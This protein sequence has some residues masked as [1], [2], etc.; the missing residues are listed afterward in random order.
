MN[1]LSANCSYL[2][3]TFLSAIRRNAVV[4]STWTSQ[5]EAGHWTRVVPS[6]DTYDYSIHS[7]RRLNSPYE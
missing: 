5:R 7:I 1:S 2:L 4:S 6:S 3:R